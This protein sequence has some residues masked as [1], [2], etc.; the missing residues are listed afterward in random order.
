MMRESLIELFFIQQSNAV[1]PFPMNNNTPP[2]PL[3]TQEQAINY[4]AAMEAIND[5]IAGY[6]EQIARYEHEGTPE[7]SRRV[8][9]LNMR[10]DQ[11]VAAMNA[12]NVE[13]S[14]NVEQTLAEYSA[15]VRARDAAEAA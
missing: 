5:V 13:D 9:W 12:L 8:Q 11:A 3:W 4:E 1:I 10:T 7:A 14:A 6:S 2:A 15:I